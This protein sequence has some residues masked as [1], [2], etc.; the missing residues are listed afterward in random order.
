VIHPLFLFVL[1]SLMASTG[2]YLIATHYKGRLAGTVV[3]VLTLLFFVALL[4][5]VYELMR[6]GGVV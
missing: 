1:F 4:W 2:A 3:G 6:R 5:G